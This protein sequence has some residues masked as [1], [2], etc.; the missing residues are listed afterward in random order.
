MIT[1]SNYKFNS[2]EVNNRN[3]RYADGLVVVVVVV[4]GLVVIVVV[5]GLVVIVVVDGLVVIVVVVV[6]GLVVVVEKV[7]LVRADQCSVVKC[8]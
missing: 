3:Q 8:F 2:K 7:E 1:T 6:D 4:D 5:D